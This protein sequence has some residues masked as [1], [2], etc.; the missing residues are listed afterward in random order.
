MKRFLMLLV[1]IGSACASETIFGCEDEEDDPY[2]N[3]L[4][5]R[6]EEY[7]KTSYAKPEIVAI[8]DNIENE[9]NKTIGQDSTGAYAFS[10]FIKPDIRQFVDYTLNNFNDLTEGNKDKFRE[11]LYLAAPMADSDTRL[12]RIID[13]IPNRDRYSVKRDNFQYRRFCIQMYRL[14]AIEQAR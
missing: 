14:R 7:R 4:C 5:E 8:M 9:I 11:V 10:L 12:N 2:W 6:Q 1:F 3:E 13:L